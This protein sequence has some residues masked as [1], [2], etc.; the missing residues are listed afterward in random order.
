MSMSAESNYLLTQ[1]FQSE[2]ELTN[3]MLIKWLLHS[4]VECDWSMKVQKDLFM[5]H[6]SHE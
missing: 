1:K 5:E 2:T 6:D 3:F 4:T